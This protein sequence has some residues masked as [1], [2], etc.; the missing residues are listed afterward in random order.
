MFVPELTDWLCTGVVLVLACPPY[1]TVSFCVGNYTGEVLARGGWHRA[2]VLGL[3][4]FLRGWSR[5][6][7]VACAGR[8]TPGGC[9]GPN[10]TLQRPNPA[11][12][13]HGDYLLYVLHIA[14]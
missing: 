3:V 13:L 10:A 1:A 12:P 8:E 7:R 4:R 5:P 6:D 9:K 2:G 11:L 14:Y